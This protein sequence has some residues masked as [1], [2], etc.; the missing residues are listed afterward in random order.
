MLGSDKST[1]LLDRVLPFVL[2]FLDNKTH[3]LKMREVCKSWRAT[4]DA[5]LEANHP[6]RRPYDLEHPVEQIHLQRPTVR[7]GLQRLGLQ[8]LMVSPK[9]QLKL[10]NL[11]NIRALVGRCFYVQINGL[12]DEATVNEFVTMVIDFLEAYGSNLWYFKIVQYS[13]HLTYR[14][15]YAFIVRC[16]SLL[17]NLRVFEYRGALE[18]GHDHELRAQHQQIIR[19]YPL[20]LLKDLNF[21][22]LDGLSIHMQTHLIT[23]Y[24]TQLKR[25]SFNLEQFR[26]GVLL[27]RNLT[28]LTIKHIRDDIY[29]L[30]NVTLHIYMALPAT[31]R[32]IFQVQKLC[33]DL[34]HCSWVNGNQLLHVLCQFPKLLQLRLEMHWRCGYVKQTEIYHST[35][36]LPSVKYFELEAASVDLFNFTT[37]LYAFPKLE[38][39]HFISNNGRWENRQLRTASFEHDGPLE[40]EPYLYR[41]AMEES[42]I[43][44]T[45]TDLKLVTYES[46]GGKVRKIC[47]REQ[48]EWFAKRR[49]Q[50]QPPEKH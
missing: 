7:N 18:R 13:P 8:Y 29:P 33:L 14:P 39:L 17:P 2:P 41:N 5:F 12:Y 16:L 32:P 43:W 28:E 37:M 25:L 45:L 31:V 3:V 49:Q 15:C 9:T 11:P 22:D 10:S 4:V 46:D 27:P 47:T 42:S 19:D 30:V 38:Y 40:I 23:F 6:C 26:E 35:H 20:P 24:E 50:G 48:F 21:L 44:N 36:Q 1:W 34:S